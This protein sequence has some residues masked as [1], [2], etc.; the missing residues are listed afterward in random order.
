M[1][2]LFKIFKPMLIFFNDERPIIGAPFD[3]LLLKARSLVK[4]VCCLNR[5]K[6]AL[7]KTNE[8]QKATT[9]RGWSR[10]RNAIRRTAFPEQAPQLLVCFCIC[11]S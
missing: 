9:G 5:A 11:R 1:H 7:S 8:A 3:G 6:Q 2:S 10:E 4:S